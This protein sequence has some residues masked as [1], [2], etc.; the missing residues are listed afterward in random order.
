[1]TISTIYIAFFKDWKLC[2]ILFSGE[3]INLF[4]CSWLL[5]S[6]LIARKSKNFETSTRKVLMHLNHLFIVLVSQSS[7]SSNINHHI[8]LFAC[9]VLCN[10]IIVSSQQFFYWDFIGRSK[11]ALGQFIFSIFENSFCNHST[12]FYDVCLSYINR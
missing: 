6:E 2:S 10:R 8:N 12:H 9:Y 1:M 5:V 3:S 11:L 4:R 7:F